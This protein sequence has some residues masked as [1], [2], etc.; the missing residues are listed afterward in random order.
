MKS[1][2]LRNVLAIV[3]AVSGPFSAVAQDQT[4][5]RLRHTAPSSGKTAP[6][7]SIRNA[8]DCAVQTC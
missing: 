3:L 7:R 4:L 8:S 2:G 6:L 1:P 5:F